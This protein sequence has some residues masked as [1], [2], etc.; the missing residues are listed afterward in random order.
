MRFYKTKE[1]TDIITDICNNNNIDLNIN[2][3]ILTHI[4]IQELQ[5]KI[6]FLQENNI[7]ITDNQGKLHEIFSISNINMQA[8]YNISLEELISKYYI[9]T[10][11]GRGV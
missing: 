1:N 2:K 3:S 11:G 5:S 8:K 7:P 10:L 4:S 9:P 6:S